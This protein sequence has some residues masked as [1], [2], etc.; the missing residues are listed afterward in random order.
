MA[1]CRAPHRILLP[2]QCLGTRVHKA[3]SW[4][5]KPL[6]LEAPSFG[7]LET[8]QGLQVRL[9]EGADE[10][11]LVR[12]ET[13]LT[14]CQEDLAALSDA[15]ECHWEC[16]IISR[17][18]KIVDNDEVSFASAIWPPQVSQDDMDSALLRIELESIIRD[19]G[20]T[21]VVAHLA[22]TDRSALRGSD[23]LLPIGRDWLH[24]RD[25]W[26]EWAFVWQKLIDRRFAQPP[27]A[28]R[29]RLALRPRGLARVG[30]RLAQVDRSALRAR[31]PPA[32]R[33]RLAPGPRGSARVVARLA[34]VDRSALR[35]RPPPADRP[36]LAP[37]PRALAEF[38][39]YSAKATSSRG[40]V[41][42]S[43]KAL[44]PGVGDGSESK[45]LTTL[46]FTLPG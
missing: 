7:L 2:H 26:P 44:H 24:G 11:E 38:Q 13:A 16:E 23:H 31:P 20:A 17:A 37:R 35:A 12:M 5:L 40:S 10:G 32:N 19:P 9:A 6:D 4:R 36:R 25:D 18:D 15:A 14:K 8:D 46:V 33:P 27:P 43:T 42:T 3:S 34:Q 45:R 30:F 21:R 29:P 22:E 28:D 39:L 1:C 41:Q